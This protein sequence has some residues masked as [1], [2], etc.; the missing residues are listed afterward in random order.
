MSR[1]AAPR[2]TLSPACSDAQAGNAGLLFLVAST[3]YRP[4]RH[5]HHRQWTCLTIS[6]RPTN[7]AMNNTQ[8]SRVS[9]ASSRLDERRWARHGSG[10]TFC[11]RDLDSIKRPSS[12]H[13]RE[14]PRAAP[15]VEDACGQALRSSERRGTSTPA[16]CV[17]TAFPIESM[18][19]DA[20]ARQI[21]W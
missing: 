2:F 8:S 9:D 14:E 16:G 3:Q 11:K 10:S 21:C 15:A 5:V 4:P 7:E 19:G 18:Y 12:D 6:A 1:T 17:P 20:A 13:A